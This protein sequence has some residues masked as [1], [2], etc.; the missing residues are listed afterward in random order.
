MIMPGM[1]GLE[2]IRQIRQLPALK[3]TIIIATSAMV[4][5]EDRQKSLDTG[6]SAFI[7]KP[8]RAGQLLD[9]L[10]T[11]LGLTWIYEEAPSHA[12]EIPIT[13][14]VPPPPDKLES[15]INSAEIGDIQAIREQADAL[16]QSDERLIPFATKL[17]ELAKTFQIEKIRTMLKSYQ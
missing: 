16:A 14:I 9:A 17:R 8:I 3:D 2:L 15:L 5:E 1:D 4:Y 11:S 7:P 10:Q 13:E 6:A 12:E